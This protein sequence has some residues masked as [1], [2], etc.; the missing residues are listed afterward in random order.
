M[1]ARVL[2]VALDGADG[3]TLDRCTADGTLPHLARLRNR[4]R[5]IHLKAPRG[6]TDD[7]IWAS[8]KYG[9]GPGEHGR[10]HWW[11]PL[12]SGRMGM[13]FLDETGREGFWN[14]LSAAGHRVAV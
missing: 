7:A 4:S 3:P 13:A 1:S 2:I 5:T 6:S 12:L 14:R 8:F 10:Y 11:Q 9:V